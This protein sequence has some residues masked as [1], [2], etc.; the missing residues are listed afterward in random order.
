MEAL[1]IEELIGA[2]PVVIPDDAEIRHGIC[3]AC[4][5]RGFLV[6]GKCSPTK[7]RDKAGSTY[8]ERMAAR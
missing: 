4:G 2:D 1:T 3:P 8:C 7:P 5:R 6:N